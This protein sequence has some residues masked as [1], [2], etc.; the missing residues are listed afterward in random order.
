MHSPA[1]T[2]VSRL[3]APLSRPLAALLALTLA[4]V[5]ALALT[6]AGPTPSAQA[7]TAC[8]PAWSAGAVY[9]GGAV[10][11]HGGQNWRAG[12]WTQNE[13]PGTTG[14]WGVWRSQGACAGTTDPGGP[15][16]PGTPGG[17]V[18]SRAQ[19][20]Q[21]FPN[22]NPFYTYDGLVAALSAYPQFASAGGTEI[23]KREAAA[24]LANVNHE[25]GGLV[26]VK[27]INT[28]N[29]PHYC[30]RSQPYG[31]P[32]GQ[33]AYYG[34]GP[35]QLSWNY[36][37]K[38]AGDALGIDLLNNPYLVETDPAVAW[39]TGLWFWNTQSGAGTM[40]GHQAIVGGAGFGESIRSINGSIEC[41]GGNPAQ[42][43]SRVTAFQRFAQ[44]LGTTTGANLYC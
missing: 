26:Y 2:R 29:Y 38:A 24:F 15:T 5:A 43:Q 16:D 9:T 42:V 32:A 22:R 34:K 6:T 30:D 35:V 40:S 27:E 18:V 11:S 20:D 7:A 33:S 39:K 36:N 3:P 8:A 19:F 44:I 10:V 41:N 1:Q 17:F 21:M 13:R 23:A 14:E 31:C 28:A 37:Y 4:L 25:T 12:W